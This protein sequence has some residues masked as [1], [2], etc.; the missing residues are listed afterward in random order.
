M[1]NQ[2][3]RRVIKMLVDGVKGIREIKRRRVGWLRRPRWAA[4][5][6]ATQ[7]IRPIMGFWGSKVPQNVRFPAQDADEP[8]CKI[9]HS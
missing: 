2:D 8:L 1:S 5:A 7:P 4:M 9:W 6:R 3:E